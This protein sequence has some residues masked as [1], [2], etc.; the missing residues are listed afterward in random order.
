MNKCVGQ[1][2]D[3]CATMAGHIFGVKK[4]VNN[5]YPV[6]NFFR[7]A[8]HRLNLVINDLNSLAEVRNCM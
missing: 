7:C 2:Y 1:G 8:S 5:V 3:G 6:A 4:R